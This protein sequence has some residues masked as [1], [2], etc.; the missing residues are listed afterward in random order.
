MAT[1]KFLQG[2]YVGKLGATVGQRW[3]NIRT[4]RSYVIPH[5]PRTEVQQANRQRFALAIKVAQAGMIYNKS[6]PC[7]QNGERTEFQLRTSEAKKRID[8]GIVGLRAVPLYPAGTT[9][10]MTIVDC[11]VSEDGSGNYVISSEQVATLAASRGF[12]LSLN[13]QETASGEEV[14]MYFHADT[15]PGDSTLL[16]VPGGEGYIL[17]ADTYIMGITMDDSEHADSFVFV[18]PQRLDVPQTVTLDDIQASYIGNDKVRLTSAKLATVPGTFSIEIAYEYL[19]ASTGTKSTASSVVT[20]QTGNPLIGD[21]PIGLAGTLYGNNLFTVTSITPVGTATTLVIPDFTVNLGQKELL[22]TYGNV[23]QIL[24][25]G[26]REA[27]TGN[28][29]LG[30]TLPSPTI[31]KSAVATFCNLYSGSAYSGTA[32]LEEPE[33]SSGGVMSVDFRYLPDGVNVI[34]ENEYTATIVLE[35]AS[36][37]ATVEVSGHFTDATQI[38]LNDLSFDYHDLGGF[39]YLSFA[40]SNADIPEGTTFSIRV[41]GQDAFTTVNADSYDDDLEPEVIDSTRYVYPSDTY[42]A[43]FISGYAFICSGDAS[44][45]G[46]IYVGRITT[47]IGKKVFAVPENDVTGALF[48][49]NAFKCRDGYPSA[50]TWDMTLS[51]AFTGGFSNIRLKGS[52]KAESGTVH[53]YTD[54]NALVPSSFSFTSGSSSGSFDVALPELPKQNGEDW[55]MKIYGSIENSC[56]QSP[57]EEEIVFI[58]GL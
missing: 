7:W 14:T 38:A 52:Y 47:P 1:Q 2:G 49:I 43:P 37:K 22:L 10:E 18:A 30:F 17:T 6:A 25:S 8:A 9:P 28:V 54:A 57:I 32:L 15:V 12:T 41:N 19:D 3:K 4:V 39:E 48:G 24:A 11:A 56:I 58:P 33:I 53:T 34:S 44:T 46:N 36:L 35:V 21:L 20:T 55:A 45:E 27:S 26:D 40:Y 5:N 16:V 13:V 50:P 31:T 23:T 29:V 42:I 51:T